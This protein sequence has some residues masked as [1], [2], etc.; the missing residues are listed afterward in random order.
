[1]KFVAPLLLS[2]VVFSFAAL[3]QRPSDRDLPRIDRSGVHPALIVEGKPFLMLSA[4]VNNSSAWQGEMP[5][6]WRTLNDLGVNTLEA[7]VYWET[8]EPEEGRFDFAQIDMLLREARAHKKHLVLLWF[9]TWK[10]GSPGYAPEWVKRDPARFP[11][12]LKADG[13]PVFSLSPFGTASLAADE[14]A[15]T[16]LMR[17]LKQSDP[18]HTVLLIQVENETGMWGSM[19]DHSPAADAVFTQTVPAAVLQSMGKAKTHGN[20]SEIFGQDAEEFFSAWAIARYVQQ[21][22]AAGKAVYG[23]PM[24]VNAALRDPIH[25]GG[26]GS[27]ESGGP[28]FDVL[29]LWHAVAPSL[30]GIEPDIYLPGYEENMA[31]LRQYSA[32][33]NALFVPEIGNRPEYARYFF[34]AL[35]HG[36][37][38]WSPFGMDATGY[39]NAPLGAAHIDADALHPFEQNYR[40]AALFGGQLAAWIREGRVQGIAEDHVRHTEDIVLGNSSWKATVS[41]GLPSFWTDKPAPGNKVPAGEALIVNLGPDEFLVTGLHCRVDFSSM[42]QG[43]QHMW[44][45]VEEG[46]YTQGI[47]HRTRLWNGDQTDYGLNFFD[48]PQLLRVR[49]MSYE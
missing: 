7:P 21:V 33:G 8:L 23:L 16:T 41:Y 37:F 40:V 29:T 42:V 28:T 18:Q 2:T 13:M 31:V 49:I 25:P 6:V 9:G 30:D 44:I 26:P 36:A 47:W 48:E 14:R 22:A 24:Y 12:S 45:S 20:W 32:D 1:M 3:A 27:F 19:R 5:A 46:D 38:G 4:Q 35:G 10:N 43:K 17:H 34:A 11:L 39:V 15:F